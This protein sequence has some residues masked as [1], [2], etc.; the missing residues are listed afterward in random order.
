MI[1]ARLDALNHKIT[2]ILNVLVLFCS[3]AIIANI[4]Y[5]IFKSD[6]YDPTDPLTFKIQLWVCLIFMLD[7][8]IRLYIAPKKITFIKLNFLLLVF[9]IPYL[10][11][12]YFYGLNL[13]VEGHFMLGLIPLFRAGFGLIVIVRWITKRAASSLLF[14]YLVLLSALTYFSSLLFFVAERGVN[15]EVK[16]FYDAIWWACMDLTTVGSNI[17]AV[18]PIGKVLSV[19]IAAM[20]M[21]MLPVFVVFITDKIAQRKSDNTSKSD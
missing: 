21:M 3:V 14:S 2:N 8:L 19:L 4:S 18:T 16:T 6:I 7:F 11:I 12:V 5:N 13:S 17:I 1:K 20:G 15:T 9:S 10:N